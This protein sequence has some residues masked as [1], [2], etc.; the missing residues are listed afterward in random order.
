M[1]NYTKKGE[2][3]QRK[4]AYVV[5]Y[6]KRE[7]TTKAVVEEKKREKRIGLRL[8]I[9]NYSLIISCRGR[10]STSA[11]TLVDEDTF[12]IRRREKL[13]PNKQP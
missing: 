1:K 3:K 9:V 6:N 5:T 8:R 10:A 13:V 4:N 2:N 7:T 11:K 12:D